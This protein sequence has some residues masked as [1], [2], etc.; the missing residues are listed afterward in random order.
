MDAVLVVAL[1]D[2]API[3]DCD[4][5]VRSL[6]ELNPTE[7]L[8]VRLQNI[9]LMLHDERAAFA[10][11]GFHVHAAAMQVKRHELIAIMGRPV[12]ALVNH[13]ADVRMTTA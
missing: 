6:P 8:V 12:V 2:I 3:E 13:H 10:L 5:S 9:G 4:S 1:A 7:P 11:D